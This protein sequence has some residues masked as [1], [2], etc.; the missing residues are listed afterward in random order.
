[1]FQ[2][3]AIHLER[4]ILLAPM[5]DVSEQPFRRLC[6]RFGADLV[7]TEFVSSEGLIRAAAKTHAKMLLAPDEHPVG[8][9]LLWQ[10]ARRAGRGDG[11]AASQGPDL[12][13]INFGCLVKK[14]AC[15]S[16]AGSTLREPELLS[17]PAR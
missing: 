12:I 8:I 3:G 9:Q 15:K 7:Y 1:M 6:R 14:I 11:A 16:G 10:L 5:E 13:D 4:P 2:V 17:S